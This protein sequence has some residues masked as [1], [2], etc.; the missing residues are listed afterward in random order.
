MLPG[1]QGP[2]VARL[3]EMLR[4]LGR[5]SPTNAHGTYDAETASAVAGI[6]A[7][8]GMKVDGKAGRQVRCVLTA[9]AG[10]DG[11][12]ALAAREQAARVVTPPP[13]PAPATPPAPPA[14]M[15]QEAPLPSPKK[16]DSSAAV[17]G[18]DIAI[19]KEGTGEA[20]SQPLPPAKPS[21]EPTNPIPDSGPENAA[22]PD[23]P[24]METREL[25]PAPVFTPAP[26][27][28]VSPSAEDSGV[29]PPAWSTLPLLPKDQN[30]A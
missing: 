30:P 6:Q 2:A 21:E 16:T 9:W 11:V 10:G 7:E 29:T 14:P 20:E 13:S 17:N 4:R 23:R 15:K 22:R 1:Q 18:N 28:A 26:P 19:P 5:L 12:P 27:A 3:K 25:P 24:A 8:T